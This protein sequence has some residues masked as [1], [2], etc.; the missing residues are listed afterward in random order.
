MT[1]KRLISAGISLL[2]VGVVGLVY[3]QWTTNGTGSGYAKA[4]T[5]TDLSTVDVSANVTTDPNHQLYPGTNGDVLV[6]IHNPNHYSVAVTSV[7]TGSGSV[8]S[9][10]G[11]GTC[12]TNAVSLN[13]PQSVSITI[14]AQSDSTE[15]TLTNA[16][17]MGN[18]DNGCQGATF[19]IP[20]NLTGASNGS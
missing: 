19:T 17:H 15:T 7:S 20:V 5:E 2:V 14:P 10:G 11:L 8:S 13:S 18:S 4:G 6:K 12:T 16:A 1:R 9:S 3:A